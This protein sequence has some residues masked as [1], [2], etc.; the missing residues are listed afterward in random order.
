MLSRVSEKRDQ[1]CGDVEMIEMYSEKEVYDATRSIALDI[2]KTYKQ[3]SDVPLVLVMILKGGLW[4]GYNVLFHL[5]KSQYFKDIRIGHLGLSSYKKEK[6]PG[7]VTVTYSL[8]LDIDD[9]QGHNVCILDDIADTG[10]T[11]KKATQILQMMDPKS[12]IT[13]TLIVREGAVLLP[14]TAGF[15]NSTGAFFVGCGMGEGEMNR[16]FSAI[17][18]DGER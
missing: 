4:I 11:L 6:R 12:L 14:N 15:L 9:I 8:D 7:E 1:Y 16:H 13:G 17:Y 18:S 2:L 5:S 3:D 10:Q